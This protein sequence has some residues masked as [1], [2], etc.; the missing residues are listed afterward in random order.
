MARWITMLAVLTA[1]GAARPAAAWERGP[2]CREPTVVDEMTR[3][4]RERNYY[5]WVDPGLVTEQATPVANVVSCQV[6]VLA[7]PW[8]MTRFGDRP[9][10]QCL[11]H[12][13]EVRIVP[14]GFVVRDVQ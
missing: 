9:V 14:A 2:V 7:A 4:I 11:V 6:C 13:F 5:A 12:E 3:E 10:R 8:E 1:L